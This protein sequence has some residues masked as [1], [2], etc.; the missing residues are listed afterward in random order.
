MALISQLY[1]T[2]LVVL[3]LVASVL[4]ILAGY[5]VQGGLTV[6]LAPL[7]GIELPAPSLW[8]VLLGLVTGMVTLLG[9]A[10]PP[11]LQ[12][13]NVPALRV[14]RRDLGGLRIKTLSAYSIGILAFTFLVVFQV[15]NLKMAAAIIGGLTLVFALISLVA[16]GLLLLLR[17]LRKRGGSA[18]RFGLVNISRRSGHSLAQMIG[19]G[20]GL[21]ALLLL[22]VVRTD[23]LGEW[24]NRLPDDLPNRFLINI[25]TDQLVGVRQFLKA[26]QIEPPLL[27]PVVRARLTKINGK[28]FSPDDFQTDRGKRLVKREFNLSWASE[29]QAGNQIV[30]GS[31]WQPGD[32]AKPLF[33]VE[34]SLARELG[35][36][37]GD[38]LPMTSPDKQS[39]PR[40]PACAA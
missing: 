35:L 37:L 23:L 9:F 27:Y 15:Q 18:W 26:E 36:S 32:H 38:T 22:A 13:K 17:P 14:L 2:Q 40:S 24:Q 3:G 10:I 28:A 8:P 20:V 5:L 16:W 39:A 21:M 25:H 31:W 4:G 30:E 6:F 29:V 1:I 12:L 11:V 33:S 7:A 34:R 19:F